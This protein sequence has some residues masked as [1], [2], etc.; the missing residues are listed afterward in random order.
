[1][2]PRG[3]TDSSGAFFKQAAAKQLLAAEQ[4]LLARLLASIYGR[5]AVQLSAAILP[6]HERVL[7][8]RTVLPPIYMTSVS[9][10]LVGDIR[11]S[12][13]NLPFQDSSL[14]LIL[15]WHS[16]EF[17]P[18]PDLVV[19]RWA[20][21]LAPGG[22]MCAVVFQ[23]RSLWTV[24]RY[25][26]SGCPAGQ[27]ISNRRVQSIMCTAGLKPL[28]CRGCYYRPPLAGRFWRQYAGFLERIGKWLPFAAAVGVTVAQRETHGMT[29]ISV[30]Q[31]LGTRPGILADGLVGSRFNLAEDVQHCKPS[32][33]SKT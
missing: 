23:P 17:T 8:D 22:V 1:M 15:L 28:F 20:K 31:R 24:A 13:E 16:L 10:R 30:R 21:L 32:M 25:F 19:E 33:E 27:P 9:N 18:A 14:D 2:D 29:A 26:R 5:Y 6:Q 3:Q 7:D 11:A 4:A 12:A